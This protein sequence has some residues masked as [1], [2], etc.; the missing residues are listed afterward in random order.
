MR[1]VD[2]VFD[3]DTNWVVLL[4]PNHLVQIV[5]DSYGFEGEYQCFHT[6]IDGKPQ[7]QRLVAQFLAR[8]VLK[9][10]SE[11]TIAMALQEN[12]MDT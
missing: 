1:R 9:V 6:L 10:R 7:D 4:R 8:D 3:E 11:Y 12:W 5:A 2:L